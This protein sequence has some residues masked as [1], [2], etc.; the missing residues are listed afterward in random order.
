MPASSPAN[1]PFREPQNS[2]P[3]WRRRAKGSR[4]II[5]TFRS[6]GNSHEAGNKLHHDVLLT[7]LAQAGAYRL[8]CDRSFISLC[9]QDSQYILAE[10]IRGGSL[11][12]GSKGQTL[13]STM[14]DLG[15]GICP[16]TLDCYAKDGPVYS[17]PTM[18]ACYDYCRVS[19]LSQE[20]KFQGHPLP[21]ENSSLRFYCAVPL[22]TDT[23][24]VLGT[25][26]VI[27]NVPR[28]TVSDADI[29]YLQGLGLAVMGHLNLLRIRGRFDRADHLIKGLGLFVRGKS[30]LRDWWL[31]NPDN[32]SK[33]NKLTATEKQQDLQDRA[34]LAFGQMPRSDLTPSIS[35]ESSVDTDTTITALSNQ[36]DDESHN[37]VDDDE[38]SVSTRCACGKSISNW[39]LGNSYHTSVIF[40]CRSA[41][42]PRTLQQSSCRRAKRCQYPRRNYRS[43]LRLQTRWASGRDFPCEYGAKCEKKK[44]ATHSFRVTRGFGHCGCYRTALFSRQQHYPR[45]RGARGYGIL[46]CPSKS[47]LRSRRCESVKW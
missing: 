26:S 6:M 37:R 47:R 35:Q 24:L 9:D 16:R 4:E 41:S 23:G 33:A 18:H 22:R 2:D 42:T 34:N 19:D 20:P 44:C 39:I 11:E 7:A 45:S 46:R 27:D 8:N 38:S 14:L 17:T 28:E 3:A 32:W 5:R 13:A 12:A 43:K 29:E 10:G 30:T 15:Q 36:I 1:L 25:Y 31:A 21:K 40:I